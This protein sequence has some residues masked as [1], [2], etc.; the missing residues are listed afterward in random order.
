[1]PS[2]A[3]CGQSRRD[4]SKQGTCANRTLSVAKKTALEKL[5]SGRGGETMQLTVSQFII[6]LFDA[7]YSESLSEITSTENVA[8]AEPR[9]GNI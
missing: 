6:S 7:M 8:V 9:A 4:P 1:M 5:S 2:D 3:L